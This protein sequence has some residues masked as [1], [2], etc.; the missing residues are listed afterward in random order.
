MIDIY[1]INLADRPDRCEQIRK[2]FLEYTNINLI[3]ID[4]I[5]HSNG[6]IGCTRS[7]K[8]C[9]SIAKENAEHLKALNKFKIN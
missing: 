8:K 6:N 5:K 9:V 2:D 4:A 7:F 3:F 1:V